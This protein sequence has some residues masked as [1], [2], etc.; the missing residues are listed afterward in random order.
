MRKVDLSLVGLALSLAVLGV[1][2]AVMAQ[3]PRY[4]ALYVFGDS[5]SDTGNAWILMAR[6]A[7]ST[8]G[9]RSVGTRV[10]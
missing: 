8:S 6:S 1:P 7:S 2:A 5:I 9:A 4:E 10:P 3:V